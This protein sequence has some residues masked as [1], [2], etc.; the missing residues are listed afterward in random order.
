MKSIK[1]RTNKNFK[2][3]KTPHLVGT[4]PERDNYKRQFMT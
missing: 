2:P 1:Y 4:D 3:R